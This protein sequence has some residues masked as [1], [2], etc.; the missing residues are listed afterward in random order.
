MSA[1][2]ASAPAPSGHGTLPATPATARRSPPL[3]GRVRVPG[4]KS[5]SH[6]ALIFGLF[7]QGKTR[8]TGLLEGEDVLNTAKACAAL[9]ARV[10]RLGEGEWEVEGVG[11]RGLSSPAAPLDFGNSGTG[12]RLMMGAVAGQNVTATFDGDASLRRRPMKRVLDPLA[13]MGVALAAASEGGRLPL[14]LKG[15]ATLKPTVYETP[16]PSAQVKSAVLL[17]GLGAAGETV[18]IEREATRDH[19]ERMLAHF[20]ADVR[21]EPHGTHGRRIT[22]KGRPSLIAAPVDVPADPSSAAFPLVAALIVPGSD[23]TLTD[24]MMNPLRIGLVTTLLEMGADIAVVAERTE[25]GE[26]V[27]DLRV[28]HS[29]LKGVEVPPERAPA[30]IDEYPVLAV[31]AAFAEGVTRMRGLSELRVKESDR[32]AAVAAG[33]AACGIAHE[34]K[35]DDLIVTGSAGV[36]GGGPVETHMDHRI[37]MSFLVLGLASE[38]GVSVDDVAFIATSFPTFMPM[39]RGLGAV[40]N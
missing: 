5:V 15:S 7:A 11:A 26:R 28:R 13:A 24:V 23:V 30:M 8:I 22:L 39:M 40:I 32:L 2:S 20:G 31:A 34:V 29:R 18:V 12:V 27:A 16:V 17:A 14:T 10:T 3:S 37:A 4:D 35:G 9:G 19:T 38:Q 1:P 33:L 21:V 36:R 25:G 6:R